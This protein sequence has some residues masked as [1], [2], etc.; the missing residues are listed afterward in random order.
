MGINKSIYVYLA[1]IIAAGLGTWVIFYKI[2]SNSKIG[3]SL[4]LSFEDLDDKGLPKGWLLSERKKGACSVYIDKKKRIEGLNSV[5]IDFTDTSVPI[6]YKRKISLNNLGRVLTLTGFIKT[7]GIVGGYGALWISCKDE[8]GNIS[9]PAEKS[10]DRAYGTRNWRKFSLT[11][12]YTKNSEISFGVSLAGSGKIWLD[13]LDVLV[14]NKSV[15]LASVKNVN[16]HINYLDDEFDSGINNLHLAPRDIE[17]L[18]KLCKIWGFLKYYHPA[19]SSG[20]LDWDVELYNLLPNYLAQP[21]HR[22]KLIEEWLDKIGFVSKCRSCETGLKGNIQY[23]SRYGGLFKMG[24]LPH[25]LANK[26]NYIRINYQFQGRHQYVKLAEQIGNPVFINENTYSLVDYEDDGVKILSL[27]SYWNKIEYFYPYRHLLEDWDL[28]L[29]KSIPEIV[30]AKTEVDFVSSFSKLIASLND[31]HGMINCKEEVLNSLWGQYFAPL[32]CKFIDKK[33]VLT[34]FLSGDRKVRSKLKVGDIISKIDGITI[35]QLIKQNLPYISGSNYPARLRNLSSILGPLLR[36]KRHYFQFSVVRDSREFIVDVSALRIR[37]LAAELNK[38]Y[39]WKPKSSYKVLNNHIGYINT[40]NLKPQDLN[41]IIDKFADTKA[42][43]FDLRGY[44]SVFMPYTFGAWIKPFQSPFAIKTQSNL[45]SPG[46]III[47]GK[48]YNGS[49][50]TPLSRR[51]KGKI[52]ILVNSETQSQGEFTAMALRSAPNSRIIGSMT[53]GADGD[54]SRIRIIGNITTGISGI[55]IYS[56]GMK[57]V[58]KNGIG[59]DVFREPTIQGIKL[60]ADELLEYVITCID[61]Q[62]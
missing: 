15:T 9:T 21:L 59:I 17:D 55:G 41:E 11:M 56:T 46:S 13:S 58:Q 18:A 27:F 29:M 37:E 28:Q 4:N 43:I 7:Q 61:K 60:G 34:N 19:S 47:S 57:Q 5:V 32:E 52:F 50:Y 49:S 10:V 54:F 48:F 51:Y 24:Y 30:E 8:E 2:E 25:K 26:L 40:K 42:V 12:P 33:L 38:L 14:D 31:S 36:T 22:N 53:A 6:V 16:T 23:H 20:K 45:F 62:M 1:V 3:S 35:S 39:W 44:P